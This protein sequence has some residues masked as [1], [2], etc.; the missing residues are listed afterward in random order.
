MDKKNH[1]TTR[2]GFIAASG[3]VVSACTACGPRMAQHRALW[4][5]LDWCIRKL[6]RPATVVATRNTVPLQH[7]R[8]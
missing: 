8:P 3:F 6:P 4:H 5:C 2:R 1:F 7:L